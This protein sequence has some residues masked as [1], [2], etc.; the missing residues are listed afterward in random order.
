MAAHRR[1]D[2]PDDGSCPDGGPAKSDFEMVEVAR[3]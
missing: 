2:I 1:D 3:A